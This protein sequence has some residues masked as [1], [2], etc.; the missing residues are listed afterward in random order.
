[1]LSKVNK[2]TTQAQL[3]ELEPD[4][5]IADGLDDALVLSLIHI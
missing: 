2:V 1:M 5:L 4:A 3:A